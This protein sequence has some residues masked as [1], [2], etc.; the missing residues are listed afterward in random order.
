MIILSCIWEGIIP[1]RISGLDIAQ[2]ERTWIL[3]GEQGAH[4]LTVHLRS[5]KP[6]WSMEHIRISKIKDKKCLYFILIGI[7]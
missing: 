1:S 4:E 3:S 2:L 7:C 5:K 6:T